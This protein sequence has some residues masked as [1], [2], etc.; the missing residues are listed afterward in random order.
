LS[1]CGIAYFV[2]LSVEM[3]PL[4]FLLV[5]AFSAIA[6]E[7]FD[8]VLVVIRLLMSTNADLVALRPCFAVLAVVLVVLVATR[9]HGGACLTTTQLFL[10]VE[11]RA[12]S[13]GDATLWRC[14]LNKQTNKQ[15]KVEQTN[16]IAVAQSSMSASNGAQRGV[17]EAVMIR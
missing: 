16:S 11:L 13:N 14:R 10:L 12:N 7:P 4:P 2:E 3:F 5:S 9:R 6:K 1:C 17:G 8:P 15:T